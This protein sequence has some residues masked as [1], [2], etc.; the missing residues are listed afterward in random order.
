M[1]RILGRIFAGMLGLIFLLGTG[2]FCQ[3]TSQKIDPF[4][5]ERLRGGER[6][7][8]AGD[9]ETAVEEMKIA[10]VGLGGENELMAKAY[11]YLGLSYYQLKNVGEAKTSLRK[12]FGL[13]DM[14]GLRALI[15]NETV[16]NYLNRVMIDLGVREREGEEVT[17][18]QL[19]N[20]EQRQMGGEAGENY[21][22]NLEQ[23]IKSNPRN[24]GLYY[25][26][27]EH[28]MGSGNIKE[29]RKTL[30]GLIKKN[31]NEAKAYYLLGRIQYR[32]RGLKDA[33]QNL[34]K[35]FSIQKIVPVE[36]HVLLEAQAYLILTTHLRGERQSSYRMFAE[37]ADRFTVERIRYL[38]LEEQD[39][40]IFLAIA[41]SDEVRAEI[42]RLEAE[43]QGGVSGGE[44]GDVEGAA[45]PVQKQ[46]A[47]KGPETVS[48]TSGSLPIQQ[49]ETGDEGA[50]SGEL[51]AGDIV[52]LEQVDIVPVLKSRVD[53]KYPPIAFARRIEGNVTV[54]ALISET[55]DVV[56]VVVVQGLDGGFN[57]ATVKAVRQWKYEPAVK[58][59]VK[60]KVWKPITVTFRL[61]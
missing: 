50:A 21:V 45:I 53:L 12:A 55:G 4:Y 27:Y 13:L 56:E 47:D 16:W 3:E 58:D 37:W 57:D 1:G 41:E 10:V 38:D 34:R 9:F 48:E 59:G 19:R 11:V 30:E 32:Q 29:A 40:N 28:H 25:E 49:A 22:K 61:K 51:K 26:L 54:N 44:Q 46:Q 20:L 52:P 31:R 14:E 18:L 17:A 39:R 15:S 24:V 7:F 6:A 60:V 8:F 36:E 5:L 35:V 43:A 42:A 33:N 2:L 23:Q